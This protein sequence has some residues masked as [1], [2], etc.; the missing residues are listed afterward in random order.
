MRI[1]VPTIAGLVLAAVPNVASAESATVTDEVGEIYSGPDISDISSATVTVSAKRLTIRMTHVDWSWEVRNKRSATGGLITFEKGRTF[2]IV[3]NI[4]GRRS[5]IVPQ[6]YL[7]DCPDGKSCELPCTGWRYEK[8]AGARTTSV[9][10]PLRCFG[11]AKGSARV[12]V[13]PIHLI[14]TYGGEPVYDPM[15]STDGLSRG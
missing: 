3:P 4:N 2:L 1:L 12:K 13:E 8:D 7:F 15:P 10:V 11:A 6:K 5:F 14:P 9:S